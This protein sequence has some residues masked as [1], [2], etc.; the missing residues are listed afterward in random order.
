MREER[1][2]KPEN[3]WLREEFVPVLAEPHPVDVVEWRI[4]ENVDHL[5]D[6]D[7]V[8]PVHHSGQR[9]RQDVARVSGVDTAAVKRRSAVGTRSTNLLAVRG[10]VG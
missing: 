2:A 5:L 1:K 10:E 7:L 6:A 3:R 4:G 8:D 9:Y